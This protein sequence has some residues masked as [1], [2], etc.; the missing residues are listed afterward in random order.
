MR[1]PRRSTRI[2]WLLLV[3]ALLLLG[4]TW[5]PGSVRNTSLTPAYPASLRLSVRYP[6]RWLWGRPASITL[7]IERATAPTP[8][9]FTSGQAPSTAERLRIQARLEVNGA[10]VQPSGAQ[11][12][13]LSPEGGEVTLTW[14]LSA[15]APQPYQGRLWVQVASTDT[16]TWTPLAVVPLQG[17]PI[18]PAGC[19]VTC[20]RLIAFG[21]LALALFLSALSALRER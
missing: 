20:L 13:V 14:R 16:A 4:A 5:W 7:R 2:A 18:T 6:T 1:K 21:A 3:P 15:P 19:S 17:A 10:L 11:T 12:V 8:P 9:P